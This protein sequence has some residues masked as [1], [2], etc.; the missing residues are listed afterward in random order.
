MRQW[1][2]VSEEFARVS[3]AADE[4]PLGW[5]RVRAHEGACGWPSRTGRSPRSSWPA[6][7]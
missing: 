5:E 6:P 7:T 3:V 2:Q 4:A 1:D